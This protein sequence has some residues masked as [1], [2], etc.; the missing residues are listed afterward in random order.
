MNR[1]R[2]SPTTVPSRYREVLCEGRARQRTRG[3]ASAATLPGPLTGV[4]GARQELHERTQEAHEA[5]KEDISKYCKQ[6]QLKRE[7]IVACLKE[8]AD[9]SAACKAAMKPVR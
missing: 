1:L 6:I 5:C 8:H 9:L 4:Q 2:R 7:R 3:R